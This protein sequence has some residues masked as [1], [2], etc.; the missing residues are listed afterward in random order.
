MLNTVIDLESFWKM[1][2]SFGNSEKPPAPRAPHPLMPPAEAFALAAANLLATVCLFMKLA[3]AL[4][5]SIMLML[6]YPSSPEVAG[7]VLPSALIFWAPSQFC[8]CS[9]IC[10]YMNS[11]LHPGQTSL[12]NSIISRTRLCKS[13]G[14][15]L[16]PHKTQFL[17]CGRQCLQ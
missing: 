7:T 8:K 12:S 3:W 11:S 5:S 14:I 10:P 2:N 13:P 15:L 9:N 16:S 6:P 17:Y 1:N 4:F